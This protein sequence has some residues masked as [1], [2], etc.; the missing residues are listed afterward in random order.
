M[1]M[2]LGAKT[3]RKSYTKSVRPRN[4]GPR[5]RGPVRNG[6]R[7]RGV[8]FAVI[9]ADPS[10]GGQRRPA[11]GRHHLCTTVRRLSTLLYDVVRTSFT[12]LAGCHSGSHVW[13]C[14][15]GI[16]AIVKK[17]GFRPRS[18]TQIRHSSIFF[19]PVDAA[20]SAALWIRSPFDQH[21]PTERPVSGLPRLAVL[22]SSTTGGS[23]KYPG[24]HQREIAE[25]ISRHKAL[26]FVR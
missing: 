17:E 25:F 19:C 22:P 21:T 13:L 3:V 5:R 2:D 20:E 10:F 11:L 1:M 9:P 7:S 6:V 12:V 24:R 8:R 4:P 15:V 14:L 26:L 16:S 23:F 18:P